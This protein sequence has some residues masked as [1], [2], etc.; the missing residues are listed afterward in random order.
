[1]ERK[2]KEENSEEA[3]RQGKGGIA[4]DGFD[5]GTREGLCVSEANWQRL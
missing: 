3:G 1:M 2:A 5:E 4:V